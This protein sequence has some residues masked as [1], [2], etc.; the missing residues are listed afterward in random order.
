MFRASERTRLDRKDRDAGHRKIEAEHTEYQHVCTE[1]LF[2]K[3]PH[4]V[5][6]VVLYCIHQ[7]LLVLNHRRRCSEIGCMGSEN[8]RARHTRPTVRLTSKNRGFTSRKKGGQARSFHEGIA[9]SRL[10]TLR[11]RRTW[12]TARSQTIGDGAC[13]ELAAG[14]AVC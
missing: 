14:N 10:F 3:L 9:W 4:C 5:K 6:V 1:A 11:T 8:R 2:K 12:C 13:T 7:H